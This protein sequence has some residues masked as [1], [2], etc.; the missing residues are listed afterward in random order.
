MPSK[1][2][3]KWARISELIGGIYDCVLVPDNWKIVLEAI[4]NEFGFMAAALGVSSWRPGMP[5]V[6]HATVGYD[7]DWLATG[8]KYQIDQAARWGGQ[9]RL[10][11][12]PL[13]EPIV[14]SQALGYAAWRDNAYYR[15]LLKPRGII[16]TAMI[17]V[18]REPPLV[19]YIGFSRHRSAGEIGAN[20]LEGLRL[21]GPH[22]RRAVTISNLFDMKA[23]EAATFSSVL[24]GLAYGVLLVDPQLGIVHANAIA[25][26]MLAAHDPIGAQRGVLTTREHAANAALQ[27]AVRLASDDEVA[28]GARGIGIPAR[29]VKGDPCVIHVLPLKRGEM[30]HGLSQRATAALFIAPATVPTQMPSEALAL[31]YD[32][33]P[34]EKRICELIAEGHPQSEIATTLGIARSTVKFHVLSIF[35]KTGCKRQVDLL[36]LADSLRS[37]V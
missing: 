18:A 13:D 5:V 1:D 25:S 26:D 20:E 36:K 14:A 27:R 33:T 34:A 17:F 12:Y 11:Q 16:D 3:E 9:E 32:L 15:D 7:A 2:K 10:A 23:I 8:R 37:P 4:N 31:L 6:L 29:R 35:E 21:L 24:D 22:L 28:I 30:H 19:G